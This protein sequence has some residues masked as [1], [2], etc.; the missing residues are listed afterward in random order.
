MNDQPPVPHARSPQHLQY[1]SPGAHQKSQ[2][3]TDEGTIGK[4][5]VGCLIVGSVAATGLAGIGWLIF[6][7]FGWW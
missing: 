3:I 7:Y 6:W 5:L 4:I 2:W 1:Q